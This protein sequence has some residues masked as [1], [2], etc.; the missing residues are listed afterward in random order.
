[1]ATHSLNSINQDIGRHLKSGEIIWETKSVYK[2]NLFSYTEPG[3]RFINHHWLSEVVFYLLN[4]LIGLK[5]LIIFKAGL[6]TSAFLFIWLGLRKVTSVLIFATIGVLGSLILLSRSDVRPEIFSY[7]FLSYFLFAICRAK[8]GN[9]MRWLYALPFIQIFWTNMHIYFALGPI[10]L[11]LFLADRVLQGSAL[12]V[13][14]RLTLVIF[15]LTTF[16]ALINPNFISGALAPFTI[17]REYGYSIVENQNIFFLT[18]YGIQLK[19]IYLFEISLVV[20]ILSF[21]AAFKNGQRKNIFELLAALVFVILAGKMIRNFGPYAFIFTSVAAINWSSLLKT[22]R[23]FGTC[24]VETLS[25]GETRLPPKRAWLVQTLLYGGLVFFLVFFGKNIVNNNLY[26]WLGNAKRFGLGIPSGA[27]GG[28]DF[29]K[30]NGLKGP[31]F[32]NFDVGSFLIWKLFP[33]PKEECPIQL[34]A[35][36]VPHPAAVLVETAAG[37][38]VFVD[39]RPEAYSVEF[40]EKVYKPMQEDHAVWKELSER[41]EINYVF[42]AHTDI[43]PWAQTF[44]SYISKNP[45]WP[46]IYLDNSTVIFIKRTPGNRGVIE[47]FE[48]KK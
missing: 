24:G 4:G 5:G 40:F 37:C 12:R 46:L 25:K 11:F 1:M 15:V 41:Y 10:L 28:V 48:I 39:G 13:H 20:L 22:S 29:I 33:S 23:A 43:T 45:D 17:L 32:N 7:L 34:S 31:V 16:A 14:A 19:D 30:N 38:G 8:Y 6:L 36:V 9:E 42:F 3:H 44:L 21:I 35:G 27:Q 47:K 18:D 26:Q 2:T